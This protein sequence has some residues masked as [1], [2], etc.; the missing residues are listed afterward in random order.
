MNEIERENLHLLERMRRI[1]V[2][3]QMDNKQPFLKGSLNRE[4]RKRKM[5]K[6]M[7]EN[8]VF[9]FSSDLNNAPLD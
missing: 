7:N 1:M 9:A 6:I 4:A 3:K 8:E 2:H 5:V